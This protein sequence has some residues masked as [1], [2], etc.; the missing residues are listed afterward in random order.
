MKFIVMIGPVS[1]WK[2]RVYDLLLSWWDLCVIV[3]LLGGGF[4]LVV[5]FHGL[6]DFDAGLIGD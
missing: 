6:V 2:D 3:L 4:A 1:G 5:V